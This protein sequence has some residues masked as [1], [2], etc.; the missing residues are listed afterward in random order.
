MSQ[1]KHDKFEGKREKR[2]PGQSK[3]VLGVFMVFVFMAVILVFL[4][5]IGT[6]FLMATHVEFYKAGEIVLQDIDVSTIQDVNVRTELNASLESAKSATTQNVS[7]LSSFFQYAWI[8]IIIVILF[9][10]FMESRVIVE[11]DI[12]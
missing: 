4:A 2:K 12:R 5:A 3:G 9:V 10:L 11:T 8:I 7:I 1:H 6:P